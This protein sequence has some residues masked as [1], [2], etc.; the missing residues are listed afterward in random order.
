MTTRRFP[1]IW[2]KLHV[3][4]LLK[5]WKRSISS[6]ELSA[7]LPSK[8]HVQALWIS[9][10]QQNQ[11]CNRPTPHNRTASHN[12]SSTQP[13]SAHREWFWG[14]NGNWCY[15]CQHVDAS[16]IRYW[17]SLKDIRLTEIVKSMKE[18][19]L[20]SLKLGDQESRWWRLMNGLLLGSVIALIL[21]NIYTNDQPWTEGTFWFIYADDLGVSEQQE[22]FEVE[23]RLSKALDELTPYYEVNHLCANGTHLFA[24][25]LR[26]RETKRHL[27]VTWSGT[28]LKHCDH[29]VY[30]E[31]TLDHTLSLKPALRG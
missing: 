25:H 3:T 12:Q 23:E 18:N 31:G 9:H 5:P 28:I 13:H 22:D 21:F 4:S 17:R 8:S 29:P 16:F 2:K 27:Q 10:P 26:N 6:Q 7:H 24:F 11:P 30:L 20:F 14:R 1:N 15:V 19:R